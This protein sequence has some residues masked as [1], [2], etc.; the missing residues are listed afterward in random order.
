VAKNL[1]RSRALK[2]ADHA[3][4]LQRALA[5]V[6]A[7]RARNRAAFL[8][9]QAKGRAIAA[10]NR[11][12]KALMRQQQVAAA[13]KSQPPKPRKARHVTRKQLKSGV[14]LG[15]GSPTQ[16]VTKRQHLTRFG[17]VTKLP[18]LR[19]GHS[20]RAVLANVKAL[21]KSGVPHEAALR[22]AIKSAKAVRTSRGGRR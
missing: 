15:A 11:H 8:A 13:K 20:E 9:G 14:I 7:R 5:M 21:I 3:K 4:A 2:T 16:F 1:A 17:E 22:I 19:A 6:A 18:K 12:Q 10:A